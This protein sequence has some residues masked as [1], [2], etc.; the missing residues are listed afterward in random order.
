MSFLRS[1]TFRNL[2]LFLF[3][4]AIATA[5][6]WS[7]QYFL[8]QDGSGHAYGAWLITRLLAGDPKYTQLFQFNFILFPNSSGHWLQALLL[9]FFSAFTTTKIMAAFT[10]AGLVAAIG[11]LRWQTVGSGIAVSLLIGSVF[12]FNSLWLVG[13]YNFNIGLITAIVG[14]GLYFR[15]R[16]SMSTF[17]IIVFS[18]VLLFAF[19][20]HAI[21]FLILAAAVVALALLP[22]SIISKRNLIATFISFLPVG[23][24]AILYKIS[25]GSSGAFTPIWNSLKD[26][27]SIWSWINQLRAFDSFMII[28]RKSFPFVS[29]DSIFFTIFTPLIWI[30]IGLVLL[31]I[32][33]WP[34]IE[35]LSTI[36]SNRYFP[37][38]VLF[39]GSVVV[40]L[41]WPDFLKFENSTGG[42]L[43]ERVFLAGLIFLVP[44]FRID[45]A[46]HN[47][48]LMATFVFALVFLFQTAAL[49]E[50]ALQSDHDA[51][52]YVSANE[53]IPDGTSLAALRFDPATKRFSSNA[54]SSLDNYFAINRD[55][56]VWDNYEFGH[57]LFPVVLRSEDDRRFAIDYTSSNT[58]DLSDDDKL[59][60]ISSVF[61]KDHE[62]IGTLLVWDSDPKLEKAFHPYFES[63]PY[64]VNGRVRLFK[65]K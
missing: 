18:L 46:R 53:H 34:R 19:V 9:Q 6:I 1:R 29:A 32:A 44:L 43:R 17:R 39:I 48:A 56:L 2:A 63:E 22:V 5:P 38:A 49:W 59:A 15:W 45:G 37:F 3:L 4:A 51:S 60:R 30:T 26:P 24:V 58:Y 35:R 25:S 23:G 7:V 13:F 21:S 33:T 41:V 40:A 14:T 11:W 8:N 50:Y 16:G 20:S 62:R 28:S 36:I 12:A 54:I 64:F 57:Y 47:L 65:H 55:I 10:Y 61:E 31:A 52:E 27:Y 42:I